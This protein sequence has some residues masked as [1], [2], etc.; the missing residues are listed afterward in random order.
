MI[1]NRLQHPIVQAPLAGGPSTVDLA[2]AVSDAGGLGFLA[3][4]YRTAEAVRA[5]IRAVRARTG[6]PFGVNVFVPGGAPVGDGAVAAFAGRLAAEADRYAVAVGEP[7]RDDDEWE[8]KVGVLLA[9][10]PAVASFTF[11]CPPPDLIAALRKAG[12][13]VWVTVTT[14]GE[15]QRA[16]AAGADAL[17]VQGY[18]AGGHRGG[19]ADSDSEPLGL[20]A[21]LRLVR[22]ACA[23]PMVATGG[24]GDGAAVAAV[25]AAGAVAAQL[26]T[27]FLAAHEAG[28]HPAH[29]A[30]LA[31]DADTALTRAFTGRRARGI[32]NRFLADHSAD[33]PSAY[34]EVHHLT[35]PLRAAARARG[36][37][38]GFNLWAGQAH[39]LAREEAA[40]RIVATLAADARAAAQAAAERLTRTARTTPPG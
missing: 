17:V 11:G 15:A 34:P 31:S 35:A 30:A 25:L 40:G 14:P 33:A 24:I 12:S 27:A 13:E 4:G 23:L 36:D 19:F 7:R 5:E 1:C 38:D 21:L 18:E 32:V 10:R 29:R 6:V 3:G 20:L 16:E 9:E 8:G 22:A 2:V 37:G 26:G 39:E 28:T